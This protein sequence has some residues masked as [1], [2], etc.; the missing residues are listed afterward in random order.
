MPTLRETSPHWKHYFWVNDKKILEPTVKELESRGFIVREIDELAFTDD[1]YLM[2]LHFIR[3]GFF[4]AAADFVRIMILD[5]YGG[6]YL[7]IDHFLFEYDSMIN[8]NFGYFGF[9]IKPAEKIAHI[10][11]SMIGTS[12]GHPTIKRALE[13]QTDVTIKEL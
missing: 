10:E 8:Y 1:L 5:Q 9:Y 13:L 11:S 2:Y 4:A 6:L 12:P 3:N 7:D